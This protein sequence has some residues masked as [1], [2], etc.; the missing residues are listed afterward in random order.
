V[1]IEWYEGPRLALRELFE[2]AEDSSQQLDNYIEDGRVLV[3]HDG[4]GSIAGHLQLVAGAR[5][6]VF[7][8][9]NLAVRPDRQGRGIGRRLVA[10]SLEAC[11][12][13]GATTVEV[14]TAVAD[15][16]N[17]RF[18][19]RCGFRARSI[20]RDT[21]AE[22]KGYPPDLVADGIPVLDSIVFDVSLG[23]PSAGSQE[24]VR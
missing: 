19:Q 4:T 20:E 11:R 21:F 15:I 22:A 6:D 13:E 18:Y 3:A 9:K 1:T 16:D 23:A 12:H 17:V 14:V 10:Q 5:A 24:G 7:E 2:L 8:I